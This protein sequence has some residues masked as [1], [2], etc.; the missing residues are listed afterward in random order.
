MNV[1]ELNTQLRNDPDLIIKVLVKLGF[2]EDKIK[3]HAS[4]GYI[5]STRPEEDSDNLS[6]FVLYCN[7]LN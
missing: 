3:Y 4:K 5:T 7:S 1:E 2:S 6:A